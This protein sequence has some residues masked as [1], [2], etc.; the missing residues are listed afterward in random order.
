MEV[1]VIKAWEGDDES[2]RPDSVVITLL[3]SGVVCDKVTLSEENDWRY[4]WTDLEIGSYAVKEDNVPTPYMVSYL[5]QWYKVGDNAYQ[6]IVTNT[7]NEELITGPGPATGNP[8][9]GNPD[10]TTPSST[11]DADLPVLPI[12]GC[13]AAIAMI[14]GVL[15]YRRKRSI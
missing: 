2:V 5:D 13:F 7:F 12:A 8:D 10:K 9:T 15:V 11:A 14:A 6:M 1:T 4:T 3:E